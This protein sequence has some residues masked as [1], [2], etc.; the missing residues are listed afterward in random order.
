MSE[1][2]SVIS[3]SMLEFVVIETH[4]VCLNLPYKMKHY[5]KLYI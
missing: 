1:A 3:H 4:E 2:H 5:R